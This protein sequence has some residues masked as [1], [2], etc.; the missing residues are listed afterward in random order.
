MRSSSREPYGWAGGLFMK[1]EFE[2]P[3]ALISLQE[4]KKLSTSGQ[5]V[6]QLQYGGGGGGKRD[7]NPR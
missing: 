2:A 3:A 5:P 4:F 6:Q 7:E 1:R